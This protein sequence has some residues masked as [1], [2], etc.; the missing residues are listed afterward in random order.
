MDTQGL[1]GTVSVC[2]GSASAAKDHFKA[3]K[4]IMCQYE[5]LESYINC[6]N[7]PNLHIYISFNENKLNIILLHGL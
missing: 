6:L 5:I 1:A 2:Q 3:V 7:V 4:S